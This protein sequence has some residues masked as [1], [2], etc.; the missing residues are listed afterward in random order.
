MRN[1]LLKREQDKTWKIYTK[2]IQG[3]GYRIV[4]ARNDALICRG[5]V[6]GDRRHKF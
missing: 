3:V 1:K 4:V 2:R 5:M 6:L